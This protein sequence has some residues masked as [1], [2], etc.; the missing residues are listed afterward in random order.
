MALGDSIEFDT[1]LRRL[2]DLFGLPRYFLILAPVKR[3]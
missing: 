2:D 1:R 3:V